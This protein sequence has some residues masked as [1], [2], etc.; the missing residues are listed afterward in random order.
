MSRNPAAPEPTAVALAYRDG[1]RAPRL[2]AKGRGLVAEEIIRRAQSAGIFLHRS[3]ELTGILMQLDLD[4]HIPPQLYV[5][6]AELLA[7]IYR[8]EAAAAR[9]SGAGNPLQD[10]IHNTPI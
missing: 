8:T 1:D 9:R 3:R 2:V 5:V 6:I 4:R 10:S 7:W